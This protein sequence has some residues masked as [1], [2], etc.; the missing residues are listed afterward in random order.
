MSE[1][2]NVLK[3]FCLHVYL[4]YAQNWQI[5][6]KKCAIFLS[7]LYSK[8]FLCPIFFPFHV[9]WE[10][11]KRATNGRLGWGSG[12]ILMT[13]ITRNK[14]SWQLL[15]SLQTLQLI[16]ISGPRVSQT[17]KSNKLNCKLS[18]VNFLFNLSF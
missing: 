8:P 17:F 6:N 3:N 9:D 11:D 12:E 18:L 15:Q 7:C 2:L 1:C 4:I 10:N 14:N 5:W 13:G 16:H